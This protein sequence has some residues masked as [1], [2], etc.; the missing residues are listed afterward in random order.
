MCSH[1]S[2]LWHLILLLLSRSPSR[3]LTVMT[4]I[5]LFPYLLPRCRRCFAS[6]FALIGV[7]IVIPISER[8]NP[9][10]LIKIK[11]CGNPGFD[12]I[13]F[14]CFGIDYL[15]RK[16]A[17]RVAW[18][19]SGWVTRLKLVNDVRKKAQHDFHYSIFLILY[20]QRN[21]RKFRISLSCLHQT[22]F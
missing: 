10:H 2:V 19:M 16:R 4:S 3:L 5:D 7:N 11:D 13:E 15:H 20:H 9:F 22:R 1:K 6:C 12:R 17:M 21:E 18:A 14:S 8:T